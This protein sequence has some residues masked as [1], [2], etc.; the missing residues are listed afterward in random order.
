MTKHTVPAFAIITMILITGCYHKEEQSNDCISLK[1]LHTKRVIGE[2]GVPLGEIVAISA[3]VVDGDSM[4]MK[5]YQGVFLLR[6]KSVNGKPL[7]AE[8]LMSFASAIG[9]PETGIYETGEYYGMPQDLP[10]HWPLWAA[11]SFGFRNHLN[12]LSWPEK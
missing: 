8:P 6:I 7:A 10:D 5:E 12:I 11:P 3:T 2:L 9:M 1:D 4:N